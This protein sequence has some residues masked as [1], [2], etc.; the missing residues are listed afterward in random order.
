MCLVDSD[1]VA[2]RGG[3]FFHLREEDEEIRF[4]TFNRKNI[5]SFS[6]TEDCEAFINHVS[7]RKY[8]EYMWIKCQKANLKTDE[9]S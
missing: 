1:G 5:L 8:D 2:N 4:S 7:G 9:V 3:Y 6:T